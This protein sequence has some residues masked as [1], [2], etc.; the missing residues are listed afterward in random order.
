MIPY[1]SFSLQRQQ[2]RHQLRHQL[3]A[4]LLRHQVVA[5][6]RPLQ[7]QARHLERQQRRQHRPPDQPRLPPPQ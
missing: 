1:R 7:V 2:Q 3:R 5:V 4:V 6:P